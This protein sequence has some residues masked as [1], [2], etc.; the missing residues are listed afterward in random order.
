[1]RYCLYCGTPLIHQ[2]K[3]YRYCSTNCKKKGKYRIESMGLNLCYKWYKLQNRIQYAVLQLTIN[4]HS[5]HGFKMFIIYPVVNKNYNLFRL[6][7]QK[8]T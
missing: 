1:M 8:R 4:A 2:D 6:I 3:S 5:R 7:R